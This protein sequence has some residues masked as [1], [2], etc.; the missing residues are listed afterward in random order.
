[1]EALRSALVPPES[2]PPVTHRGG[3]QH[4]RRKLTDQEAMYIRDSDES[5]TD[6]ARMFNVDRKVIYQ[7]KQGITYQ[8]LL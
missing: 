3:W 7:I 5:P 8:E 1:M 4:P 6:L 2:P